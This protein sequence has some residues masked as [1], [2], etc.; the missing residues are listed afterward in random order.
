M[1]HLNCGIP[2]FFL[3]PGQLQ[4][5]IECSVCRRSSH[6]FDPFLDL[7]LPLPRE[8]GF[9]FKASNKWQLDIHDCLALFVAPEVL[10]GNDKYKCATC[11]VNLIKPFHVHII[12]PKSSIIT[13]Q[14]FEG[15]TTK[16]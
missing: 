4:S 14:H 9:K 10:N 11:K 8:H 15:F 5:T 12:F 3:K 2:H 16:N 7:S 1:I 13:T 6:C